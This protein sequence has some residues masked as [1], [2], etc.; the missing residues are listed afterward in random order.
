VPAGGW[1][2]TTTGTARAVLVAATD[3]RAVAVREADARDAEWREAIRAALAAEV[4]A[5]EE[6]RLAGISRERVYQIKDGR[7]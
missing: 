3:A 7:R 2:V 4:G 1:S 5:T 6:A